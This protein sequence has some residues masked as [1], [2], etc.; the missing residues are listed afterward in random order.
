VQ[1]KQPWD[2]SRRRRV[3]RRLVRLPPPRRPG[4]GRWWTPY[5]VIALVAVISLVILSRSITVTRTTT[6]AADMALDGRALED[7]HAKQ[8]FR[9]LFFFAE[10]DGMHVSPG[11]VR[12]A[13][14]KFSL[15]PAFVSGWFG[16]IYRNRWGVN[17]EDGEPVGLFT[18]G[19]ENTSV[20]A[21]GCVACHSGRAAGRFIVGLGNKNIDVQQVG[22]DLLLL[23][24]AW[25]RAIP[26][27]LL[28]REHM[29]V[30]GSAIRFAEL[31]ADE[32]RGNL[33]QGLVPVSIIRD[34]FYQDGAMRPPDLPRG[35]VK[36]PALWGYGAKRAEGQFCDGFGNGMKPGW[37]VAVELVAGQPPDLVRKYT[38]E[39]EEAEIA[40]GKFLPPP[41]PFD[42]DAKR[43][44]AGQKTFKESCTPCHGEYERDA[45]QHPMYLP[46]KFIPWK[47]SNVR[48]DRDR[49]D[50]NTPDF[51][52]LVESNRLSEL[53]EGRHDRGHGYFAP[54]LV[55]IWARYPYLHNGSVP[56]IAALLTP[57]DGRPSVFSLRD[58]GE[59]SRFDPE[60]LGLTVAKPG[61]AEEADLLRAAREGARDVFYTKRCGRAGGAVVEHGLVDSPHPD[62]C[63]FSNKG[64]PNGIALPDADKRNLIEYLKTL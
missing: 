33:T 24:K 38:H 6:T 20:G 53:I 23:E 3:I 15:V 44:T 10:G 9:T 49:L 13:P 62:G 41:Y 22:H 21:V 11:L 39:I 51:R 2:E 40:L 45:H 7:Q 37:A 18:T 4:G 61:S 31:L 54:R 27:F 26:D 16:Q 63:G 46:P 36:V 56:S 12:F 1:E 14:R 59:Q 35:A 25:D 48:T 58:A 19:W 43:A 57:V 28:S 60:T 47:S 50:G 34:W 52:K 64:H 32:R 17:Y 42:I 5:V 30:E 29:R 55:G 8:K